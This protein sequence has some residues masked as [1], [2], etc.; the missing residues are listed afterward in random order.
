MTVRDWLRKTIENNPSYTK[1]NLYSLRDNACLELDTDINVES[2]NRAV[3]LVFNEIYGEAPSIA[4]IE[5]SN[6][7]TGAG[8]VLVI[9]DQHLPFGHNNYLDFCE[10]QYK[11]YNCSTAVFIG[12]IIDAH[13]ISYHEHNPNGMSAGDELKAAINILKQWY[14]VFPNAYVTPG[15]HDCLIQRRSITHG[16]PSQLFKSFAEIIEAPKGWKFAH[17]FDIDGV[18]YTHGTG[19]GGDNAYMQRAM[20]Y[21]QS[22]VIGHFHSSLGVKYMASHKDL[23]FG[24]AVGSGIDIKSYA[25]EYNKDFLNRPIIGCGVVL[26]NGRMGIPIPMEL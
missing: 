9:G 19:G 13:A 14:K 3:R 12:D 20:K 17:S 23:I 22:T 6:K 5:Y 26:D 24:M 10:K 8:N 21:R 1:D 7:I 25:M 16:L 11:K 18:L 4:K 15:N 2:Y